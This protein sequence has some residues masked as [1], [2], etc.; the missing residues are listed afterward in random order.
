MFDILIKNAKYLL[1]YNKSLGWLEDAPDPK[2]FSVNQ[3]LDKVSNVQIKDSCSIGN[4]KLIV[5]DQKSISSCSGAGFAQ[6]LRAAYLLKGI[7]IPDLSMLFAYYNSRREDG[8]YLTDSGA[9]SRNT[10]KGIQKFGLC[11]ESDWAFSELQVNTMPKW[12]AYRAG[13]KLRGLKAYYAINPGDIDSVKAAM[14]HG[15]PVVGGWQVTQSFME[16]KGGLYSNFTGKVVGGHCML[17]EAYDPNQFTIM[18]SW[19]DTWAENGRIRVSNDFIKQSTS[20][21]ALELE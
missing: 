8:W 4:P 20:L 18:N 16:Y 15:Y 21:W 10:M 5:K 1:G 6:G 19:S 7:D 2:D 17:I 9:A 14:S 13:A 11:Q 12:E 3:L